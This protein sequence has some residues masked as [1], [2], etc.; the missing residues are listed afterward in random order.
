MP[1]RKI[2]SKTPLDKH[3][4]SVD[5]VP[6]IDGQLLSNNKY[7]YDVVESI[8]DYA[9]MSTPEYGFVILD[10]YTYDSST[11]LIDYDLYSYEEDDVVDSIQFEIDLSNYNI[12]SLRDL[13]LY[14]DE[15]AKE[16]ANAFLNPS[17]H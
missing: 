15:W 7:I 13:D 3:Y 5:D 14:I 10:D 6:D 4:T 1:R 11:I 12:N 2:I 16:V 9:S 17:Y 8:A